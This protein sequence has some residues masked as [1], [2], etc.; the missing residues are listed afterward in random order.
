MKKY[1]IPLFGL[2]Y[3]EEFNQILRK[4]NAPLDTKLLLIHFFVHGVSF[5]ILMGLILR[6]FLNV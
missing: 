2:I 3:Y 5:Y 6:Y 1:F 4:V